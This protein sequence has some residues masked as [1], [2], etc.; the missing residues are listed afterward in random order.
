MHL[1]CWFILVYPPTERWDLDLPT[2]GYSWA[3]SI[4]WKCGGGD[5]QGIL[6]LTEGASFCRRLQSLH[7]CSIDPLWPSL[8]PGVLPMWC[9]PFCCAAIFFFR[10]PPVGKNWVQKGSPPIEELISSKPRH[11]N[12]KDVCCLPISFLVFTLVGLTYAV[13]QKWPGG[14]LPARASV[15]V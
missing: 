12:C 7:L 4:S 3:C 14:C 1:F 15:Q 11:Q 10:S 9:M 6:H 13:N 8:L 2:V 5:G